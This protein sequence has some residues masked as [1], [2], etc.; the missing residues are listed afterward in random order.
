M[1]S[2]SASDIRLR[3]GKVADAISCAPQ[4]GG[5]YIGRVFRKTG[6]SNLVPGPGYIVLSGP[7]PGCDGRPMRILG[8]GPLRFDAWRFVQKQR[9]GRWITELA[10][11]PQDPDAMTPNKWRALEAAHDRGS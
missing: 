10:M 1:L 4:P 6:M 9:N 3:A 8:L 2:A 11:P 7:A 5:R